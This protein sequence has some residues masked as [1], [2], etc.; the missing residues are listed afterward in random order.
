MT[1][2]TKTWSIPST[3]FPC[4]W[5]EINDTEILEFKRVLH[6]NHGI[7]YRRMVVKD[8]DGRE[9]R[10]ESRRIASMQ[11]PHLAAQEYVVKPLNYSAKISIRA[12]L[13]VIISMPV[14]T[15]TRNLTNSI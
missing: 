3:G 11:D 12:G 8:K 14:S 5:L 13:M 6:F 2:K 10:I 7:L 15:V 9:T 4:D 1:L